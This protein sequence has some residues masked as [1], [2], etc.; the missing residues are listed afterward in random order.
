MKPAM[1]RVSSPGRVCLFGEH[2]DY[3][4]LDVIAAAINLRILLKDGEEGTAIFTL[5]YPILRKK[6]AFSPKAGYPI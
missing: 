3:L 4:G 6:T 2:Q 1:I 5:T